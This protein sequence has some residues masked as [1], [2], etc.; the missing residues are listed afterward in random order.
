MFA[1]NAVFL[2]VVAYDGII[3]LW[4]AALLIGLI[5]FYYVVMFN[6]A[7][8][9]KFMKR[10]FE[11][12][13]RWCNQNNYGN[14]SFCLCHHA[15][16]YWTQSIAFILLL[17]FIVDLKPATVVDAEPRQS[18]SCVY[19]VT[20][21]DFKQKELEKKTAHLEIDQPAQIEPAAVSSKQHH[22]P[23]NAR[24]VEEQLYYNSF[25]FVCFMYCCLL[26]EQKHQATMTWLRKRW[27]RCGKGPRNPCWAHFSGF[28]RG[29]FA[30]CSRWHCPI[31]WLVAATTSWRFC[32]VFCGLVWWPI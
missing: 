31:P 16:R 14:L 27:S 23:K 21:D 17:L 12:E 1:F 22:L 25:R 9:S 4:E 7:R 24:H 15:I 13:L 2:L 30:A 32:S 10:K 29:R 26:V 18:K 20:V 3:Y 19:I 6:S 11:H 5:I 28:T 8:L